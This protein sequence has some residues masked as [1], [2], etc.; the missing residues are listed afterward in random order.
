MNCKRIRKYLPLYVASD[1]S[2]KKKKKVQIHL[3]F[4][5]SCQKEYEAYA[6]SVKITKEWLEDS[7]ITWADT[8]WKRTVI[9]AHREKSEA[10]T[11]FEPWPF[12][13]GWAFALMGAVMAGLVFFVTR[14][15]FLGVKDFSDQTTLA[16]QQA[17]HGRGPVI[18]SPQDV[19]SVTMVS[20]ETGL[21]V[22]WV[23]DKNFN[24]E[25][26]E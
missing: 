24:L 5:V 3:G 12:K 26:K 8:D 14:P 17:Q 4:C 19:V 22:I 11:G 23:L 13:K 1:L 25:E 10:L 6:R 7:A 2:L 16:K 21:K 15:L 20:K 18:E 9:K